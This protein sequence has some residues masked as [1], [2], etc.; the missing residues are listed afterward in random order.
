MFIKIR[1]TRI[2]FRSK[3]KDDIIASLATFN[4][5]LLSE[6]SGEWKRESEIDAWPMEVDGILD[7][8]GYDLNGYR[9]DREKEELVIYSMFE[10]RIHVPCGAEQ[11][12]RFLDDLDRAMTHNLPVYCPMVGYYGDP[13]FTT[14]RSNKPILRVLMRYF[15]N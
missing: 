6:R 3:E 7:F 13:D 8:M 12:S 5:Q 2:K 11:Y 10:Y 9:Y 15:L 1:T 4:R 14:G